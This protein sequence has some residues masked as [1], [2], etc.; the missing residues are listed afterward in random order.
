MMAKSIRTL[1]SNSSDLTASGMLLLGEHITTHQRHMT[2]DLRE[3]WFEGRQR[4]HDD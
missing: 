1:G 4:V 3:K 2:R